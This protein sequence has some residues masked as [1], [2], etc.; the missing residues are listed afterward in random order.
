MKTTTS[1][2]LV[3]CTSY[4]PY[5]AATELEPAQ[6]C[7]SRQP[8]TTSWQKNNLASVT[9]SVPGERA[10]AVRHIVNQ[11]PLQSRQ[12]HARNL[13]HCNPSQ[14]DNPHSTANC[15]PSGWFFLKRYVGGLHQPCLS[16]N[17]DS[18]KM[19]IFR[20]LL[21]SIAGLYFHL[22]WSLR[23][24]LFHPYHGKTVSFPPW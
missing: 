19:W 21:L 4:K 16:I 17:P 7:F 20:Q 12:T 15:S 8:L 13:L 10:R 1:T 22:T 11:T 24:S 2:R 6:F 5:M 9:V 3:C 14:P 23:S 18:V